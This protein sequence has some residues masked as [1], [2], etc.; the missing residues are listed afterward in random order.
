M[1]TV[2]SNYFFNLIYIIADLFFFRK[3]DDIEVR[4][5]FMFAITL[6]FIL[7]KHVD[8]SVNPNSWLNVNACNITVD[9]R[10]YNQ[11]LQ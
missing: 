6:V 2:I 8:C 1:L 11:K 5:Q 4:L 7:R 10:R 9:L 3:K